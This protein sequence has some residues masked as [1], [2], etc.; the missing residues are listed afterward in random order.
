MPYGAGK[1]RDVARRQKAA[2]SRSARL[3][4]ALRFILGDPRGRLYLAELVRESG[5]LQRVIARDPQ[6][7]MFL[8]GQRSMGFKILNDLRAID[9][10]CLTALLASALTGEIDGSD[11]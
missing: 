7:V 9:T 8:D 6:V 1:P 3:A 10:A 4:E 2:S 11:A 5:A